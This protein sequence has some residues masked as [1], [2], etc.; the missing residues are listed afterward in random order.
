MAGKAGQGAA[1]IGSALQARHNIN[2]TQKDDDMKK[3]PLSGII[4]IALVTYIAYIVAHVMAWLSGLSLVTSIGIVWVSCMLLFL[5]IA[6]W[7]AWHWYSDRGDPGTNPD[8]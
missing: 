5:G 7:D 1:R 4:A 3:Y 8:P 6:L 2:T